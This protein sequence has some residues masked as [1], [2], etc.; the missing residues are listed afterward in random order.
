M[1]EPRQMEV[2]EIVPFHRYRDADGV[3]IDED[4]FNTFVS[5]YYRL[6]GWD[7]KTGWPTRET[8][9]KLGL[10]DVADEL[11]AMGKCPQ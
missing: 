9:E 1:T 2:A 8:Y 10:K 11:A 5:N 3:C 6:R 7:E 4:G